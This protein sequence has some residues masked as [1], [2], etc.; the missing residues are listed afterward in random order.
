MEGQSSTATYDQTGNHT[1]CVS[2]SHW[3]KVVE[4]GASDH[5]TGT[6]SI[7]LTYFSSHVGA[8]IVADGSSTTVKGRGNSHLSIDL[9]LA[10]MLYAPNSLFNLIS[11]SQITKKLNCSVS[12]FPN[13]CIFQNLLMLKTIGKERVEGGIYVFEAIPLPVAHSVKSTIP[14]MI[15]CHLGDLASTTL[16]KFYS[17][18]KIFFFWNVSHV[19]M[20][21]ISVD[22]Y[23]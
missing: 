11:V 7:F 18:F 14:Y 19:I 22:I 8:I 20:L 21:N 6:I 4:S 12:F 13:G 5:M 16:Q 2:M 15:H 3:K 1:A 10:Y 9:K 23:L 17:K